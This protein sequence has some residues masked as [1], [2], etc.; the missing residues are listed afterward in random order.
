MVAAKAEL[1]RLEAHRAISQLHELNRP[2][3]SRASVAKAY[4]LLEEVPAAKRDWNWLDARRTAR[5]ASLEWADLALNQ[6]ELLQYSGLMVTDQADWPAERRDGYEG[7][8]DKARARYY[9]AIATYNEDTPDGYRRAQRLFEE[10]DREYA[11]LEADFPN[12]PHL[13]YWRAWNA[14][15]GYGNAAR[16]EDFAAEAALLTQARESID[17]LLLIEENDDSIQVLSRNLKG[18]QAQLHS[19]NGKHA[20]AI[21]LMEELLAYELAQRADLPPGT[22]SRDVAYNLAISGT[23]YRKA[24]DRAKTCA[25]F[26]EALRQLEALRAIDKLPGFLEQFEPGLRINVGKCRSGGSLAQ[27]VMLNG[28]PE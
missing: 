9:R 5:H 27:M 14:Y 6:K 28:D 26:T 2:K 12:D 18:A 7:R 4:A 10:N 23:I 3:E 13:L 11:A 8:F 24:G 1:A 19:N 22:P 16:A 15:F 20:E 21:V 25:S 17:Q